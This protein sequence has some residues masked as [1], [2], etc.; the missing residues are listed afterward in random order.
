MQITSK[1]PRQLKYIEYLM[2]KDQAEYS[3]YL[4]GAVQVVKYS[5]NGAYP[6]A[7]IFNG[8]KKNPIAHYRYKTEED[9]NAAINKKIENEITHQK[10]KEKRKAERKARPKMKIEVGDI[11][12]TSWGY[13][14]TNIDF[15]LVVGLVGKATAEYVNIGSKEIEQ[16][17]WC[18]ADVVADPS[19]KSEVVERGR[20]GT[21]GVKIGDHD[22]S[23]TSINEK[24]H[25]SWGY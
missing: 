9:R 8:R 5:H 24:H 2:Q 13:E 12:Y 15:Y 1:N 25:S 23:K 18:S 10:Y 14:Q 3:S 16:T 21:C 4:D 19:I 6:I 11:L 22:A 17:S 7:A 20:I